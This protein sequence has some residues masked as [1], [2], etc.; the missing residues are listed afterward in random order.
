MEKL[1]LLKRAVEENY[2]IR[3]CHGDWD[4]S[5]TIQDE[6]LILWFNVPC[7][8]GWTTKII[9]EKPCEP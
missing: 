8:G 7:R 6:K 1:D 2:V 9:K 5:Y 4:R 3:A